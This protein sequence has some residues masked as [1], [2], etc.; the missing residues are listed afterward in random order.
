MVWI[1]EK[2][3]NTWF[4]FFD[5]VMERNYWEHIFLSCLYLLQKLFS[6]W[7]IKTGIVLA[8]S[9]NSR[10]SWKPLVCS[11]YPLLGGD[12]WLL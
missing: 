11:S 12:M 6:V 7:Y 1:K 5:L 8:I 4:L 3:V 2:Y 10:F 9:E